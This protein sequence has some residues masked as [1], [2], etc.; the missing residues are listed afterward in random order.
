MTRNIEMVS[1]PKTR[2][3]HVQVESKVG[4][5]G[6]V[7]GMIETAKLF[8]YERTLF[9]ATRGNVFL[10]HVSVGRVKDPAT[11]DMAEKDVFVAFFS[12]E[13]IRNKIVKVAV[14]EVCLV[15]SLCV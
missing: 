8:Q 6:F 9:K 12:G 13:R 5:V 15:S 1:T 11:G 3:F 7:A 4:R 14:N 2:E 10:K